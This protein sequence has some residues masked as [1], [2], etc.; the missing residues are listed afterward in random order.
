MKLRATSSTRL[1]CHPKL[2]SCERLT[3]RG[4]KTFKKISL[5]RY[6]K[7]MAVSNTSMCRSKSRKQ[8]PHKFRAKLKTYRWLANSKLNASSSSKD[9]SG[10][11]QS[12][13]RITITAHIEVYGVAISTLIKKSGGTHAATAWTGWSINAL[14]IPLSNRLLKLKRLQKSKLN[15]KKSRRKNAVNRKKLKLAQNLIAQATNNQMR[16]LRVHQTQSLGV[17]GARG[18]LNGTERKHSGSWTLRKGA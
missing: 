12:T 14:V 8:S 6:L 5:R 2:K 9:W 11:K 4:N 3:S 15:R 16:I 17:D 13:P 1:R 10:S 7:N 18:M